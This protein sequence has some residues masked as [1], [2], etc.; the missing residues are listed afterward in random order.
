MLRVALHTGGDREGQD[1]DHVHIWRMPNTH[2][3][4]CW[5]CGLTFEGQEAWAMFEI[6]TRELMA[7]LGKLGF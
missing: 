6:E 3:R 1:M 5:L 7:E 2:Y 4:Q